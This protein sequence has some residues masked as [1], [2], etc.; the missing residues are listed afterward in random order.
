MASNLTST[1]TDA[2]RCTEKRKDCR[3]AAG[4]VLLHVAEELNFCYPFHLLENFWKQPCARFSKLEIY[5][6]KFEGLVP[7][8]NF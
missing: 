1:L 2:K 4:C 6:H 8:T 5:Y 3:R 7:L